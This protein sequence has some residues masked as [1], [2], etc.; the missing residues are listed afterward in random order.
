MN[1][2]RG[3]RPALLTLTT[4]LLPALAL[5]DAG[6]SKSIDE[7]FAD[8]GVD[9]PGCAAGVIQHGAYI[10]KAGYGLANLEYGIPISSTS[11]FRMG[12]ISKQFTAMAIAILAE[13]G[14]LDLDADVHTYLP[15]LMDYGRKVTIRQMIHHFAGMGDYD[16]EAFRKPDG[17]EFRFG[18]QDFLTIEEFYELVAKADLALE[19]GTRWQYSNLAYFL[20]S[21]VV[22]SASGKTLRE[23]AQDE[24][25]GPLGMNASRFNDN[26][27]QII[28][29]R[30]YGYQKMPDGSWETYDTNLSW[31]G[32]GGVY[33]S[34]D[35][36]IKWDRNFYNNQLGKGGASL[37]EMVETP[38]PGMLE[39]TDDGSQ[40]ANYAFGLS[41][42]EM[43]GERVVGHTGSW[44][45][46]T[47]L[48]KRFPDLDISVV[49]FCNSLQRSAYELG[50]RV[51][52]L[53]VK[54]LGH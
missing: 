1:R 54:S 20:L 2:R 26:V 28:P 32:D 34:L 46:F 48:Y 50:G 10:H 41:V 15:D 51:V 36:F 53:S 8:I 18:N 4:L 39:D 31:V 27:N 6:L 38:L 37:I 14:D 33:T 5:A 29:N 21:Q 45:G 16:H 12:S 47:T 9:E 13:R 30:A 7:V 25:F 19:P 24:I 52:E 42:E 17:S 44:V 23:F 11:V 3:F 49:V 40:V 43:Y 22:E 35:D